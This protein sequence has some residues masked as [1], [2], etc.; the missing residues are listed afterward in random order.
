MKS[1]LMIGLLLLNSYALAEPFKSADAAAGKALVNKH[2]INCHAASYG[3]DGAAIYT[4]EFRKVNSS[5]GLI[6]QVRNC[7][8]MLGLKWFEDEELNVAKYLNLTYYQF[9]E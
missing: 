1:F 7:N 2:C 9:T 8:T 5:K 3:G 6:A 4:R